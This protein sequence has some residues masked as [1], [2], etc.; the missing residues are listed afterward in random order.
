MSVVPANALMT[1][2]AVTARPNAAASGSAKRGSVNA[3]RRPIDSNRGFGH[4]TP[5]AT[6][7]RI[8]TAVAPHAKSQPG[9]GRSVAP[10]MPC[11]E[12]ASGRA[13]TRKASSA[14]SPARRGDV[15]R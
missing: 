8:R 12:A 4:S 9:I 7:E 6:N 15:K 2:M 13:R 1:T 11:A 14:P 3:S 10:P 5:R